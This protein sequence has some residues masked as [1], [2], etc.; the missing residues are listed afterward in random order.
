M[1][2]CHLYKKQAKFGPFGQNFTGVG[3]SFKAV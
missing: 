1:Y 2:L 3:V